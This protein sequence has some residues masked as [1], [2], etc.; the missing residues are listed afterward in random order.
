[1]LKLLE[2]KKL[3]NCG[4]TVVLQS[5][6]S[7]TNCRELFNQHVPKL[8]TELTLISDLPPVMFAI[9]TNESNCQC[10]LSKCFVQCSLLM[11]RR[12]NR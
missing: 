8:L 2:L 6:G 5:G 1:M 12:E 10:Q 9:L 3:S 7:H 11:R 4:Y